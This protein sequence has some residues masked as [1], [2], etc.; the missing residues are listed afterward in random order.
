MKSSVENPAPV[1]S[2]SLLCHFTALDKALVQWETAEPSKTT[3]LFGPRD[4]EM[5]KLERAGLRKVHELEFT[6]LVRNRLY[7]YR[8]LA[9]ARG[10]E[11]STPDYECDNFFNLVLPPVRMEAN[12]YSKEAGS[13]LASGLLISGLGLP[14]AAGCRAKNHTISP[15]RGGGWRTESLM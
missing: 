3:V 14:L 8:I 12:P 4:G 5:K 7:T 2:R 10:K 15:L 13:S 6:G 1:G 9:G 11:L